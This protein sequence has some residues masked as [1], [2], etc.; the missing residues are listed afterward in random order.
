VNNINPKFIGVL[1][2]LTLNGYVVLDADIFDLKIL[3]ISNLK[4]QLEELVGQFNEANDQSGSLR[5][6]LD[7]T[8]TIELIKPWLNNRVLCN[9]ISYYFEP[10]ELKIKYIRLREPIKGFGLQKW[11]YD[12]DFHSHEKRLEMFILFDDMKEKNGCT[13]IKNTTSG[14]IEKIIATEGSVLLMDS[15]TIHRGTRNRSG[16]RRRLLSLHISPRLDSDDRKI[17]NF[18]LDL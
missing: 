3:E 9:V 11:H 1:K 12:W 6:H 18:P 7:S 13:E 4:K 5:Y 14:I 8:D 10:L 15:S 16:E 17:C 2:K